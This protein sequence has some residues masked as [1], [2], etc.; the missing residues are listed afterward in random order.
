MK[1]HRRTSILL[2]LSICISAGWARG[3]FAQTEHQL[4]RKIAVFPVYTPASLEE[5]ADKVWWDLREFLTK[6][7]RF[8]VASKNFLIQKDVFQP[9]QSLSPADAI[10]LGKLLDADAT[11]TTYLDDRV[12]HMAVYESEYG[13][14]LWEHSLNLQPSLPIAQQLPAATLKLARDFMAS[15]PYQ[16][17]VIV[18]P[19]K[20]AALY[21]DG[22]LPLFK[23]QIALNSEA[24]VGDAVQL[25]HV[26]SDNIRP[27]FS[28][29]GARVEVYAEGRI[30]SKDRN[31]ITVEVDRLTDP[32]AVK[33]GSLVRLPKELKR[34]QEIYS[35][36][37]GL[38]NRLGSAILANN[39]TATKQEAEEKRPLAAS[40]TFIVNIAVF[41]LLAF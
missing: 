32:K 11:L 4:I 38:K 33:E 17:F 13:R 23:A 16:G 30:V 41:C 6:D 37:T 39:M 29:G 22:R 5:S 25:I 9:R 10:I 19:L 40:L 12:L 18:D 26:A 20:G 27:L 8:L 14:P 35:L 21:K 28:A 34:L 1:I 36:S 7:Q 2:A 31:T 15:V 24:D 3:A